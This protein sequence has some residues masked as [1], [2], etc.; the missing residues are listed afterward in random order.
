MPYDEELPSIWRSG[1]LRLLLRGGRPFR[2]TTIRQWK[3][4]AEGIKPTMLL[5]SNGS[6]PTAL[7]AC[8]LSNPVKPTVPLIGRDHTG[9]FRTARAKEYPA[10]L[11]RAFA[12]FFSHCLSKHRDQ[13]GPKVADDDLTEF[14]RLSA[15]LEGGV[16]MPDYQPV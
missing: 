2:R 8:E 13:G 16:M 4:G 6:L 11:S 7:E 9:K 5:Y 15:C 10:A 3:F 12:L 14:V 1:I